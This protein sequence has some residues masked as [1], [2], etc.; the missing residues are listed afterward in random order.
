MEKERVWVE[1]PTPQDDFM[2]VG[3]GRIVSYFY[4][5]HKDAIAASEAAEHNAKAFSITTNF[6]PP[7]DLNWKE[8]RNQ[9]EVA[10]VVRP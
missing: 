7:G 3:S 10:V 8:D 1:Y 6:V 4:D 2:R 9:W 5:I